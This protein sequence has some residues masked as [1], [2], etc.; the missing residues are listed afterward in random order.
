MLTIPSH[1]IATIQVHP[2][3]A[4]GQPAQVDGAFI[5][6]VA[7]GGAPYLEIVEQVNDDTVRVHTL[8][9][10]SDPIT[11][12]PFAATILATADVILDEG[13]ELRTWECEVTIYDQA[14]NLSCELIALE[15][16]IDT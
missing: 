9:E 15:P 2:V 11:G 16:E 12:E 3:D 7:P 1:R 10:T 4:D 14:E 5:F 13:S 8:A 6:A